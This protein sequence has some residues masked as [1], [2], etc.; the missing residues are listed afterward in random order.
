MKT[1]LGSTT[2]NGKDFVRTGFHNRKV[3]NRGSTFCVYATQ[4]TPGVQSYGA[5]HHVD[6]EPGAIPLPAP[7]PRHN[8]VCRIRVTPKVG[9]MKTSEMRR[10]LTLRG[11]AP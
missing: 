2:P 4:P 5:A 8:V 3:Y 9:R 6:K 11:K 7:D 1:I 10:I